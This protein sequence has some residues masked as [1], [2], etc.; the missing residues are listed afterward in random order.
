MIKSSRTV[1]E[2]LAFPDSYL[3]T[4][5]VFFSLLLPIISSRHHLFPLKNLSSVFYSHD[6]CITWQKNISF[7]YWFEKRPDDMFVTVLLKMPLLYF[8]KQNYHQPAGNFNVVDTQ[9][10]LWTVQCFSL[11]CE[12]VWGY[13]SLMYRSSFNASF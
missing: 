11:V 13:F 4:W 5:A 1:S 6:Q 10:L 12:L 8:S 9:M 2:S 7:F 3:V